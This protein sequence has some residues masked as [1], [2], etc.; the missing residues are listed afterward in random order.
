MV[1]R[2]GIQ[3]KVSNQIV[4]K[5]GVQK[6]FPKSGF[7]K[8][9]PK[10]IVRSS[11]IISVFVSA[12][13]GDGI[14][15]MPAGSRSRAPPPDPAPAGARLRDRPRPRKRRRSQ[16]PQNKP[17]AEAESRLRT[18]QNRH[19]AANSSAVAESRFECDG[20]WMDLPFTPSPTQPAGETLAGTIAR[21]EAKKRPASS[22]E[23]AV[24]KRPSGAVAPSIK[25]MPSC[26]TSYF[27]SITK[28]SEKE[29]KNRKGFTSRAY[30]HIRKLAQEK[31]YSDEKSKMFGSMASQAGGAAWDKEF[32]KLSLI[33]I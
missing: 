23:S 27:S 4:F 18:S 19:E 20:D 16:T 6:C 28:C 1:A 22:H 32:K 8:W 2:N 25:G 15:A 24:L 26:L 17:S 31:G 21:H 10:V 3:K 13:R 30:H 9:C 12:Y 14:Y 33:H 7:Q 11:S 5:N 29:T